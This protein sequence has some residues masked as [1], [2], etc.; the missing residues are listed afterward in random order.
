[1]TSDPETWA[2]RVL[3]GILRPSLGLLTRR[4]WQGQEH[5]PKVGGCL[6]VSN[7]VSHVDPLTLAHFVHDAGRAPRFLGKAEVFAV[8]GVGRLITSAGQI[9]VHR[10]TVDA[11]A[12]LA[13]AN[14]AVTVGACVVV[15]PEATLT[16]DPRSWPMVAKTGA[17]RIALATGCPVIPVAQWGP[18]EILG[19]Y[20]RVPHVFPRPLVQ[21]RAGAPVDLSR[22]EGQPVDADLLRAA[23]S[24]IMAA[25]TVLLEQIRGEPAPVERFDPR[26]EGVPRTGN[27]RRG[28]PSGGPQERR[29]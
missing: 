13:A 14:A 2:Y 25:I 26:V 28:R 7:H 20:H 21:V 11:A 4:A 12:A 19:A 16:R 9:P 17:A 18:Q 10:E 24:A 5:L 6:V 15:Y 27:P 29:P 22:F 8:P 1:M 3:R 23:S